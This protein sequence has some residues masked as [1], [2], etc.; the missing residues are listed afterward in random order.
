MER[1]Y[2]LSYACFP[3]YL[4]IFNTY[5]LKVI[6]I[7][8]RKKIKWSML[9]KKYICKIKIVTREK[10]VKTHLLKIVST[11]AILH[12]KNLLFSYFQNIGKKY[13]WQL[14][15]WQ[16]LPQWKNK[17]K[18]YHIEKKPT[19]VY[20]I[21]LIIPISYMYEQCTWAKLWCYMYIL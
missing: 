3:I 2:I 13:I 17:P 5:M 12:K 9:M 7:K 6:L 21:S 4:C 1:T 18:L 8:F 15:F 11:E 10:Q 20:C 14:K 19:Q 16:W